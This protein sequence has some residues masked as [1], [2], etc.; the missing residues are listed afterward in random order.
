MAINDILKQD[1]FN[2]YKDSY[3]YISFWDDT[4]ELLR[5]K[6]DEQYFLNAETIFEDNIYKLKYTIEPSGA[7]LIA[8]GLSYPFNISGIKIHADG[9]TEDYVL[10]KDFSSKYFETDNDRIKAGEYIT[11]EFEASLSTDDQTEEGQLAI[12]D[13][14]KTEYKYFELLSDSTPIKRFSSDDTE[15]VITVEK[16]IDNKNIVVYTLNALGSVITDTYPAIINNIAVH[17]VSEDGTAGWTQAINTRT[18][19]DADTS[20]AIETSLQFDEP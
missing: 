14:I 15:L 6:W 1:I 2:N 10:S 7:D 13:F 9:T 17:K 5:L 16:D 4:T 3:Q 20:I 11:F 19:Q 12:L 18:I 8:L